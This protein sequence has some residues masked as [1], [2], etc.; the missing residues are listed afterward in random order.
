[1]SIL[2]GMPAW[3]KTGM[4]PSAADFYAVGL[5]DSMAHWGVN[6]DRWSWE[7]RDAFVHQYGF[8]IPTKEAVE[9]L[10]ALSP[11]VEIGAGSGYWAAILTAAGAD[12][13]ATD[14]GTGYPF[15]R[16]EYHP[17]LRMGAVAAV[18]AHPERNVF[19][20]WPCYAKP[21]AGNA[22]KA[23]RPGRTLA[24]ISEG[25]FGCIGDDRLFARL[26]RD[27]EEPVTV[28]SAQ[29]PSLH[30]RLRLYRKKAAT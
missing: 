14:W 2:D 13:I 28:P 21:W 22:A 24:L 30:D 26:E 4:C 15:E 18:K 20:S 27:F 29:F 1:M 25:P 8:S 17:I 16:G 7:K 9:T 19:A 23:M 5:T 6:Y 12:V 10:C 11:L 3:I